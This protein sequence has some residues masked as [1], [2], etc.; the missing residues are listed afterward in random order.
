MR[1][2]GE[3][4]PEKVTSE[5]ISSDHR[6]QRSKLC[7]GQ[8]QAGSRQKAVHVKRFSACFVKCC[9]RLRGRHS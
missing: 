4:L 6:M 1:V 2:L 5:L 3:S 7:K 8:G 9:E